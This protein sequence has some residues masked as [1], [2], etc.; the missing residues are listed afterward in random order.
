MDHRTEKVKEL[1]RQAM[2][3]PL[4]PGV[5][6]MKDAQNTII[7]I[8]KAKALKNRVSQYFGSDTNHLEKV[9]QMVANVDHFEYIV[10]DSEF[11]A[12]VL[13]CSLI[14]QYSPKYNI[15]LK[16]AKGYYYVRIS[17][18]P[19]SR[20]AIA[21]QKLDDG[22]KYMGPFV[23]SFTVQEA[24]DEACRVFQLPTCNRTFAKGKRERP[25][26]NHY[27]QQC[28]APCTGK[29]KESDYNERLNQALEFLTQG[30]EQMLKTLK[31]RMEEAAENLEFEK[32]ARLRD[33]IHAI[34]RLG[35]KQKVVMSRI[36]E[37]DVIAL[38]Q[39]VDNLCFEVF[40]F[41]SGRLSDREDFLVDSLDRDGGLPVARAEFLRR[42]Y[43]M[44]EHVPP[45]ITVDG[46]IE[47]G[48]LMERWLT[49]KAGRR[50]RIVQPQ[51]GEQAKLV[52]M[53]RNNAAERIARQSGMAGRDAAALDELARLL[54]LPEPPAYIESYDI[55]NTG[56]SDNVAGMVV[57]ENGK[58][59]KS[60]YR[61]FLIK[62]VEGQDDYGSMREVITRRLNEY[63]QHK[64]EGTGFGRLPDLILLDGGR[65]HVSAVRPVVAS[66]GLSIPVFGMVK[67]AHHRT[68]AIAEDGGEI[69]INARRSAFTL[70][71][72]IQE[73][74]H[75]W[76][77]TYHRQRRQKNGIGTVLTEIEGIGETRAKALLRH[78]GSM[79]AIR[80]ATVEELAAVKGI[81]RPAA[82]RV[83]QYFDENS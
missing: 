4:L 79:K 58:P 23:S 68:R 60:A 53:C 14:K 36:P 28:C 77:I 57:F 17:P 12:L 32:A 55:S 24:V 31:T 13:E 8:G 39:G 52:E 64:E 37:Q 69:S 15:R 9:R 3:L 38:A 78:F 46:E 25:C 80:E 1:R 18:P 10:T 16:D 75:R 83:R 63:E 47:D 33:R 48:E 72:S 56:G 82:E 19:F 44:R 11:E 26:L 74:V 66:F 29:V 81:S 41:R 5:Y 71:S 6:I 20:I 50:V 59:L 67:D 40:R 76:A 45:Q 2:A 61:R 21:R 65:G 34:E 51:K 7:Y 22:A 73:E 35:Q 70:I 43:S 27:I 30:S 62:T 42:Y 54:G 49:E